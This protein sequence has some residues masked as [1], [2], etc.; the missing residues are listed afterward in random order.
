MKEIQEYGGISGKYEGICEKHEEICKKYE[1]I[2]PFIYSPWDF[3]KFRFHPLYIGF[4]TW[5]NSELRLHVVSGTWKISY[6]FLSMQAPRLGKIPRLS[7]FLDYRTWKNPEPYLIQAV[8][9]VKI[10]ISSL[11]YIGSG[12]WKN[13]E[14]F[15][16]IWAL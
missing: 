12:T 6:L 9:L 10:P 2:S 14:L 1:G 3:D 11:L 16:S 7:L 8:R 15:P 13:S 4:G 5:K